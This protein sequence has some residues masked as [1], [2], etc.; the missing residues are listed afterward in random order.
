M[1]ENRFLKME[2]GKTEILSSII[3]SPFKI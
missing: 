1:I 2:N 3:Y